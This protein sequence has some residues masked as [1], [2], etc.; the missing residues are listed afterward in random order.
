V[1]ILKLTNAFVLWL[2]F[3][4]VNKENRVI[5]RRFEYCTAGK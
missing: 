2:S 5:L 4:D 3:Y 1:F